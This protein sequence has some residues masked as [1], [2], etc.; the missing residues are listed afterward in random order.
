M[1]RYELLDT[2]GLGTVFVLAAGEEFTHFG[3]RHEHGLCLSVP[4][5]ILSA[6]FL[7]GIHWPKPPRSERQ[8]PPR[9]PL[10]MTAP[11]DRLRER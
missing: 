7:I 4:L 6:L 10:E 9:R 5:M 11:L 2:I 8:D 3:V 1:R